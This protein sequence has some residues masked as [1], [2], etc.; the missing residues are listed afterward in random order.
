MESQSK[1]NE[2]PRIEQAESVDKDIT[3]SSGKSVDVESKGLEFE[4]FTDQ[5]PFRAARTRQAIDEA[6][7]FLENVS[8]E[9]TG[10][11]N[12]TNIELA[13]ILEDAEERAKWSETRQDGLI[14]LLR[15]GRITPPRSR[16][17]L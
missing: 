8:S 12:L 1:S 4:P 13:G 15:L 9:Q 3:G 5:D 16:R 7:G 17:I 10:F 2:E 14:G 6:R 11:E